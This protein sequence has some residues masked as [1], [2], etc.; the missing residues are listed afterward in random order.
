MSFANGRLLLGSGYWLDPVV[1][2]L[3]DTLPIAGEQTMSAVSEPRQR[4]YTVSWDATG[5]RVDLLDFNT[6]ARLERIPLPLAHSVASRLVPMITRAAVVTADG[7]LALVHFG[8]TPHQARTELRVTAELE[9]PGVLLGETVRLR[10]QGFNVG[11]YAAESVRLSVRL[12]ADTAFVSFTSPDGVCEVLDGVA[13]CTVPRL[14]PGASAFAVLEVRPEVAGGLR[15]TGGITSRAEERDLQNNRAEA[16]LPVQ[17]TTRDDTAQALS[18]EVVEVVANDGNFRLLASV[19]MSDPVFPGAVIAVDTRTGGIQ[20]LPATL[21]RPGRLELS[22][23]GKFLHVLE[24]GRRLARLVMPGG[25]RDDSFVWDESASGGPIEHFAAAPGN[26]RRLVVSR[27]GWIAAYED[28]RRLGGEMPLGREL[29]F[30]SGDEFLAHEP[31]SVP[32]ITTR[33]RLGPGGL[34]ALEEIGR[35]VVVNGMVVQDGRLYSPYG[36]VFD[37]PA[38]RYAGRFL[39]PGLQGMAP[40]R[41]AVTTFLETRPDGR[42]TLRFCWSESRVEIGQVTVSPRG[43][44]G[45]RLIR[46]GDRG[47]AFLSGGR[48]HLVTASALPD[49]PSTDLEVTA[50]W[51]PADPGRLRA[52]IAW[53][54][55]GEETLRRGVGTVRLSPAAQLDGI[56]GEPGT[57]VQDNGLAVLLPE[58]L[59]GQQWTAEIAATRLN[60]DAAFLAARG[61]SANHDLNDANNRAVL[62]D[63]APVRDA[64]GT[65]HVPIRAFDAV[66]D[67]RSR[68]FI[69][70]LDPLVWPA[71]PLLGLLAIDS[72]SGQA[73]RWAPTRGVPRRLALAPGG[74]SLLV[75]LDDGQRV[76]R[77]RMPDLSWDLGIDSARTLHPELTDIA[78]APGNG[79]IAAISRAGQLQIFDDD[80]PRVP[81]ALER[82]AASLIEFGADAEYLW[83]ANHLETDSTVKR[84]RIDGTGAHLEDFRPAIFQSFGDDF[85]IRG[86]R[87]YFASGEIV[88]SATLNLVG[89]AAGRF[90]GGLVA[91]DD[92]PGRVLN[93]ERLSSPIQVTEADRDLGMGEIPADF[94]NFSERVALQRWGADGVGVLD[95]DALHL[96]RSPLLAPAPDADTDGDGLP[97]G[98]ELEG[99][100]DPRRRDADE[101]PDGDFQSNADE[102]IAGTD[103]GETSDRLA[104]EIRADRTA[105]FFGRIGRRYRMEQAETL[106]SPWT[107]LDIVWDG[108]DAFIETPPFGETISGLYLRLRIVE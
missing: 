16:W 51:L 87:L 6:S 7:R 53:A 66:Y 46:W 2:A 64:G 38:V 95:R 59:P 80:V 26:P 82:H 33:L 60:N 99:G 68:Q 40:N 100:L 3:R 20:A 9:S 24:N 102:W 70:S 67:S 103:P 4:A 56:P 74:H 89:F 42:I 21:D 72:R 5:M 83:G 18:P 58:L 93:A 34:E 76:D 79:R 54:N 84:F 96:M 77:H 36:L 104:L 23:D 108:T 92:L 91:A 25:H 55:R 1:G 50:T 11:N 86:S 85:R 19:S 69:L 45:S 90:P 106:T 43:F 73:T 105:R 61:T 52:R 15:L 47:L 94:G 65:L 10:I 57:V 62:A 12:P 37:L 63:T 41:W 32:T 29:R 49:Q 27:D 81:E 78:V 48:L 13:L 35:D 30:Y 31:N 101:D 88:D 107:P 8:E 39:R 14:E 22:T 44:G 75:G 71:E 97:D 28:G 98:W 17:V